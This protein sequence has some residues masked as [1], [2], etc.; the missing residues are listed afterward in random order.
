M[1]AASESADWLARGRTHQWEGRPVDAML[2][3]RRA[4][5]ADPRAPDP[6]FVLGEVLWQFGR[7]PD[8][9]A[10]WREAVRLDGRFLAAWQALAEASLA[11]GD[12]KGARAAAERVRGLAPGNAR[13]EMIAAIARL[14]DDEAAIAAS[15]ATIDRV[16]E[17]DP[18]LAG[19]SGLGGPLALALDRAPGSPEIDAVLVRIGKSSETLSSTPLLLLALALER[20]VAL[21]AAELKTMLGTARSRLAAPS[22]FDALRRIAV[23]V[24]RSDAGTGHELGKR[25]ARLC[26]AAGTPAVPLQWPRRTAG[27]KTRVVAL[28]DGEGGD[29]ATVG[30][31]SRLAPDEL[32][33]TF[34]TFGTPNFLLPE[35]AAHLV[36]PAA[37]DAAGKAIAA[38]DPDVLV[39]FAGMSTPSHPVLAQHPAR[40]TWTTAKVP[41]APPLIDRAFTDFEALAVALRA[42]HREKSAAEECPLDAAAMALA[43]TS[44]LRAHQQRDHATALA[45]Y[46]R[47][48]ELQPGF[49]PA[50][51]FS[52]IAQRDE[53]ANASAR[54]SLA[55][56]LAIAPGYVEARL[57]AVNAAIAA[58]DREE[59]LALCDA[60]LR[61]APSQ[62]P[63]WRAQG[64]A[65]L[66][67]SDGPAAAES[68]ARAL[69]LDMADG[70]T[71]YNLG[72]ALQMQRYFSE[73]ARAYQR[74]LAFRPD[75]VAAHFNLGVLFQEQGMTDAAIAA[76]SEV[77]VVDPTSVPAY[78]NLGEV[79]LAAGRIDAYIANFRRFEAKCPTALPLAVQALVAC[80]HMADFARLERYIDGLRAGSLR[81]GQRSGAR[82]WARGNPLPASLLR[83]RARARATASRISTTSRRRHASRRAAAAARRSDARAA[84]ASATFPATCATT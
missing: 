7:V 54:A 75:L 22:E 83:C 44:A 11:T 12:A 52:G 19:A 77:L 50:H 82:R 55:A 30:A 58:G 16:V 21:S 9:V 46:A 25:L 78:R 62:A 15:A 84:C 66:A 59:A 33:I 63:L 27:T 35:A 68:F 70:E 60:G 53:G 5:R 76:Y 47:V 26:A 24:A 64:R 48:L 74:A 61:A 65:H 13:A 57:A 18:A 6:L 69:E 34:V 23:A 81:G 2:C 4:S 29:S 17:L 79:L 40:Q 71:H 38:L 36:L 41:Y 31:L 80:Q 20:S 8:A 45:G 72:V 10:S 37:P 43:W 49:A 73:A 32:A 28:V 67:R 56:A 42:L 51:Y 1:T 14:M 3:F 39:D